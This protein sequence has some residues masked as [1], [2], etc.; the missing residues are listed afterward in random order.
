LLEQSGLPQKRQL[1]LWVRLGKS[2]GEQ[3]ESACPQAADL[4]DDSTEGP[5]WTNRRHLAAGLIRRP[6]S[7]NERSRQLRRLALGASD[8]RRSEQQ[9][10]LNDVRQRMDCIGASRPNLLP[11]SR[12]YADLADRLF[13][14]PRKF[15]AKA[16]L[17]HFTIQHRIH[18]S[19]RLTQERHHSRR[20]L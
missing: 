20:S 10:S 12:L 17:G 14:A 19:F 16:E 9:A 18:G 11:L 1:L 3:I 6:S 13:S 15:A 8:V 5:G 4:P 2:R 7:R